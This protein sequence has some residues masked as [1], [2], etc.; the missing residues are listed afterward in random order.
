MTLSNTSFDFVRTV[1]RERS[2]HRLDDDKGYLVETRLL[3][4]ARRHGFQSVDELVLHLCHRK[5]EKLLGELVEAMTINE[6]S[7]FRDGH[8]FDVLRRIVIPEL[9]ARCAHLRC[10]TIW[11]GACASG[12]E[13]YSLAILL[14]HDFPQLAGWNI[15]LI[16]SDLSTAML[17]RARAG[18]FSQLEVARGLPAE[19]LEMHFERQQESWVIREEIRRMVEFRAINLSG[20]WPDLPPLDL[21]LL[22]NVLIYFDVPTRQEILGRIRPLLQPHGYLMLGGAETTFNLTDGFTA[23]SFE[24]TS[25]FRPR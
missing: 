1:L 9:L 7:F 19:L 2:A 24:Q 15:R 11:S 4:M 8:P 21:V 6:T 20:P 25:L 17:E 13:P 16:A 18:R 3:P 14:R 22:R 5:S 10:I 12:Q 23:V